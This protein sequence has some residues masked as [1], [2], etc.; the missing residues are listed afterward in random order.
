LTG[1]RT[2]ALEKGGR[3]LVFLLHPCWE[4]IQYGFVDQTVLPGRIGEDIESL[5]P[6]Q[7]TVFRWLQNLSI[8]TDA[9]ECHEKAARFLPASPDGAGFKQTEVSP[10]TVSCLVR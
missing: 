6:E 7:P 8:A 1:R 10:I 5:K 4:R 9:T 2:A 3:L